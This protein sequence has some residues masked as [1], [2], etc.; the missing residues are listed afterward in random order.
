MRPHDSGAS[1]PAPARAG[2]EAD[3]GGAPLGAGGCIAFVTH[4]LNPAIHAAFERLVREAPP[5]HDVFLLLSGDAPAPYIAGPRG[6]RVVRVTREDVFRL[7]Y[8]E[9]CRREGWRIDGNG[10]LLFLEFRRRHPG[11]GRF[12][13]VEYDVHWEGRWGVLFEHFRAS[14]ADVLGGIMYPV[15]ETPQKLR[16]LD[17]P[18]LVLPE[19][20]GWT[21]ERAIKGFLPICRVSGAALD[22]MDAAYRGGLGGHYEIT[23]FSVPA[24]AGLVLE[25]FGGRG[26]YVR[27]ENRDRFYFAHSA[28]Y[29]HSP[30]TFVFR[31]APRVLPRPNTLWHPVK[32]AGVPVWHPM[33]VRGDPLKNALEA[34][35]P[36]LWQAMVRLWFA[37]R[38]RPLKGPG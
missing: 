10:D 34:V 29:S 13:F 33:R 11:Y 17:Y 31:P 24:R 27:P 9:K 28:T 16:V 18:R 14:P 5:D 6:D 36:L 37:T 20:A 7:G 12:W 8:P 21:P 4:A 15:A 30:G 1:V 35:K 22:A 3:P 25:D 26:P 32:P 2:R 19:G 38:W 23:L